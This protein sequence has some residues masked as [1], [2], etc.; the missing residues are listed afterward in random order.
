MLSHKLVTRPFDFSD[1]DY[2]QSVALVH[3]VWDDFEDVEN[4]KTRDKHR[5]PS[6]LFKRFVTEIQNKKGEIE[7]IAASGVN[8][9]AENYVAGK[10]HLSITATEK[11]WS[12]EY[13]DSIYYYLVNYLNQRSVAPTH[14]QT[15][16]RD[17]RPHEIEFFQSNGFSEVLRTQESELILKDFSVSNEPENPKVEIKSLRQLSKEDSEWQKKIYGLHTKIQEDVPDVDAST[18]TS[19]EDYLKYFNEPQISMDAWFVAIDNEQW[20]GMSNLE[21]SKVFPHTMFTD[22]TGVLRQY[23]RK[24]IATKLKMKAMQFAKENGIRKIKTW[25]EAKNP[26]LQ[27]NYQLGFKPTFAWLLFEKEVKK[28]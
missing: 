9:S 22:L 7:L 11:Y 24:K 19:M 12:T 27:L 2:Q 28:G 5:N 21:S 15:S 3:K 16:T 25:N 23:R 13:I 8:E 26:M 6:F 20:I 18:P 14:L 10:Y 17:D 1:A 4:W